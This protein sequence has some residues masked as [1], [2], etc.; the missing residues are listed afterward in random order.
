MREFLSAEPNTCSRSTEEQLGLFHGQH[1]L[2]IS[3][4][5]RMLH[6]ASASCVNNITF[7]PSAVKN[8]NIEGF[9]EVF[10]QF[11]LK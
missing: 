7:C 11:D 4:T 10:K 6:E 9:W 3:S 8:E 2:H 1:R 5:R